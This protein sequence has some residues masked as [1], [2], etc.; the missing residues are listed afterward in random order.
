L[1]KKYLFALSEN[2][3]KK[4]KPCRQSSDLGKTPSQHS[5][6][7][8]GGSHVGRGEGGGVAEEE[9]EGNDDIGD[10]TGLVGDTIGKYYGGEGGRREEGS[11][12]KGR[13]K[14]E[15]GRGKRKEGRRR[16]EAGRRK[17]KEGRGKEGGD[18]IKKPFPRY[19]TDLVFY[20]LYEVK[21]IR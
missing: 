6:L 11:R 10:D 13:R 3:K 15:A 14:R 1:A 12:E 20:H 7:V 16:R 19:D 21:E 17:R 8:S 2:F 18:T 9:G 4:N 5:K